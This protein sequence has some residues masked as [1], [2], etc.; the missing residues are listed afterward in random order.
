MTIKGRFLKWYSVR[1]INK[2][3][4]KQFIVVMLNISGAMALFWLFAIISLTAVLYLA[5]SATIPHDSIT[6]FLGLVV[7]SMA[8]VL[9]KLIEWENNYLNGIKN[10]NK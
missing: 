7:V 5:Q 8:F 2:L 10:R 9:W 4:W 3:S 6:V 1:L